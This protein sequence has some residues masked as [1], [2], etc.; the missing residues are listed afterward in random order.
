MPRPRVYRSSA[1]RQKAFRLRK[2]LA[3]IAPHVVCCQLG[4][5]CTLY[6]G[7]W[8][9]LSA[10]LPPLAAVVTD[11]PYATTYDFTTPRR[12]PSSWDRNFAGADQPFDPTPWLQF[13]EVILFGADHYWHPQMA[14]G[15]WWVWHKIPPEQRPADFVPYENIWLSTPGPLQHYTQL[16]RGGMR[17]GEENY[18]H[19]Q[20]KLHPAQKPID[21]MQW[22]V[23][24][25]TA[26]WVIDPF[27]GSGS[28][29]A[30]CV[31]LGRPC[32]GVE[33]EPEDFDKGAF[34]DSDVP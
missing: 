25:T 10:V 22:L 9:D 19:L 27:M 14:G 18:V 24:E 12:R 29:L 33:I 15:S 23:Q 32:I 31:R 21:L 16:W 4:V 30:A 26:P 6:C 2:R 13:P 17:E 7:D 5:H 11:P 8:Q 34:G 3:A 1:E 28:T 20:Q